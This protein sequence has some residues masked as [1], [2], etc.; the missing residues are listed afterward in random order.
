MTKQDYTELHKT[1]KD[2]TRLY[3]TTQDY[4]KLYMTTLDYTGTQSLNRTS[5]EK[6]LLNSADPV[7]KNILV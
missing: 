4:I 2:Y 5:P 1:S 7:W 6:F 3:K